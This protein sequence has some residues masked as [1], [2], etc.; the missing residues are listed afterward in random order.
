MKILQINKFL[1]P[2][3]GAET[4]LLNLS[5][6]LEQNGHEVIYFSQKI[7]K[8]I[9]CSQEKYFLSNLE[10]DKFH[11][12]T[13]WRLGRIFWSFEAS[14]KI[15]KLIDQEK[16][17]I[18]HIHNIYH[19]ISPSILHVIKRAGIPIV[20][21]AHDYKLI[22]PDYILRADGKKVKP[23]DSTLVQ[24][25]LSA[26]F[27]FHRIINVYSKNIKLFLTPSKFLKDKL[28]KKDYLSVEAVPLFID[29]ADYPEFETDRISPYIIFFGRLHESKGADVLIN[30]LAKVR[31]KDIKLKLAGA[32]PEEDG[33][34]ALA[35]ELK[36]SDRVE[37]TGHKS[38]KELIELIGKSM[39]AVVPS[40]FHETFGLSVLES[41]ACGKPV[42]ATRAGAVPELINENNGILFEVDNV[43]ELSLAIDKILDD[44]ILLEKMSQEGKKTAQEFSPEKHY[45]KINEIYN[46]AVRNK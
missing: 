39:F 36:I 25:L 35:D 37:F 33:L 41:F 30:A 19:Q 38:K 11:W 43:K 45:Q 24:I 13:L 6:L 40:R 7:S 28:I 12:K 31:N 16:P 14:R 23:K 22:R 10:L 3:G 1:Y 8:N 17:D 5:R 26:E 4:Y 32:G 34:K 9:P 2:H 18:V 21:T 27:Y 15:K 46:E 44:P 42:I 20:M 29:L